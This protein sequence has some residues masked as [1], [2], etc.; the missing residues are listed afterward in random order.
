MAGCAGRREW[1]ICLE[2]TPACLTQFSVMAI[3]AAIVQTRGRTQGVF[4]DGDDM[5]PV[6]G[7]ALHLQRLRMPSSHR[8]PELHATYAQG[9]DGMACED[10]P[11]RRAL[12]ATVLYVCARTDG[13]FVGRRAGVQL[14]W[15]AGAL[16]AGAPARAMP[17]H[18]ARVCRRH[19]RHDVWM[20]KRV[21]GGFKL[22]F[23]SPARVRLHQ[24]GTCAILQCLSQPMNMPVHICGHVGG[25]PVAARCGCTDAGG[26]HSTL[27]LQDSVHQAHLRQENTCTVAWAA[28]TMDA[29]WLAE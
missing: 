19:V 28:E 13:E 24:D 11:P 22:I 15:A 29:A 9:M 20:H 10:G 26:Q 4:F 12:S 18:R 6:G 14:L 3:L 17:Q 16:R 21:E 8:L 27:L 5:Q 1:G 23:R 25:R 7:R 2:P